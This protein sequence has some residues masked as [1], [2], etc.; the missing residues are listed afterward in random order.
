MKFNSKDPNGASLVF[1]GHQIKLAH[2]L[3]RAAE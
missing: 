3:V 2:A 1:M